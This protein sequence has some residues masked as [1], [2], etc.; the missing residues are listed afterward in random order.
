MVIIAHQN[1]GFRHFVSPTTIQ[2]LWLTDC[3]TVWRTALK[4][5]QTY[6]V[7]PDALYTN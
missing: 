3:R 2:F 4:Y 1:D 6:K 7:N 5:S